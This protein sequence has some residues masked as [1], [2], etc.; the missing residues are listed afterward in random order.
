MVPQI[1]MGITV[2]NEVLSEN[3]LEGTFFLSYFQGNLGDS[4]F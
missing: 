3:I 1:P 4:F 2:K